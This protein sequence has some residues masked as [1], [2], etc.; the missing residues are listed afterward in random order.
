M[1]DGVVITDPCVCAERNI[2]PP[3]STATCGTGGAGG[4]GNAS[5]GG[6]TGGAIGGT[7]FE[8]VGD[9]GVSYSDGGGYQAHYDLVIGADLQSGIGLNTY[10][11][12]SATLRVD[13]AYS[14]LPLCIENGTGDVVD[15][16]S[17]GV[18][19]LSESMTVTLQA[20]DFDLAGGT[21]LYLAGVLSDGSSTD[22]FYQVQLTLTHDVSVTTPRGARIAYASGV[23]FQVGTSSDS[24][25]PEAGYFNSELTLPS[26]YYPLGISPGGL[27]LGKMSVTSTAATP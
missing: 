24:G 1:I 13:V 17:M 23:Q 2:V 8:F 22:D 18:P 7:V 21:V 9:D 4:A 16:S 26:P 6:G 11:L 3:S 12:R 10:I 25:F 20:E 14:T 15:C 27:I 5:G 19:P